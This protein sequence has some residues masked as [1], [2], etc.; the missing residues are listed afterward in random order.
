MEIV[1][2][3]VTVV[4]YLHIECPIFKRDSI[5]E[6]TRRNSFKKSGVVKLVD[7]QDLKTGELM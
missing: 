5:G 1:F 2:I 6:L 4:P 3:R 7:A